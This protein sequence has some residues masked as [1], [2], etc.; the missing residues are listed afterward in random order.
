MA[1]WAWIPRGFEA[2]PAWV[3]DITQH[4]SNI[5]PGC[6]ATTIIPSPSE[7]FSDQYLNIILELSFS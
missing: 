5:K 3:S 7:A 6:S 2:F 1:L 4:T